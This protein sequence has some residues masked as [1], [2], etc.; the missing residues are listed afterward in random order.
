M[1]LY[2]WHLVKMGKIIKSTYV[3]LSLQYPTVH[4][5]HSIHLVESD[6][7]PDDYRGGW[8]WFHSVSWGDFPVSR[9]MVDG[10]DINNAILTVASFSGN[11]SDKKLFSAVIFSYD[12]RNWNFYQKFWP[13][14]S[15]RLPNFRWF[16][17]DSIW[18]LLLPESRKEVLCMYSLN[19][20]IVSSAVCSITIINS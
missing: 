10:W 6:H 11:F 1:T 16:F 12:H 8:P 15:R 17:K 14:V 20:T 13:E 18:S 7:L 9:R 2:L 5:I 3:S 19:V 4:M